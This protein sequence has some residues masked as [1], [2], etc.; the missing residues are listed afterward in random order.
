MTEKTAEDFLKEKISVTN[1]NF[2]EHV[3]H[4]GEVYL[5]ILEA[6]ESYALYKSREASIGF[7]EWIR[8]I[9]YGYYNSRT[10][11]WHS[12]GQSVHHEKNGKTTEELFEDY[13]NSNKR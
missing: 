3:L 11:L 2:L 8:K 6:M 10:Q 12:G 1:W 4:S 13:L 5:Q 7:A 9:G